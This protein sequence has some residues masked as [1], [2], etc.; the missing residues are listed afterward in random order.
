MVTSLPYGVYF[1]IIYGEESINSPFPNRDTKFWTFFIKIHTMSSVTFHSISIWLTVYLACFRYIFIK[2]S[3]S[4]QKKTTFEKNNHKSRAKLK[5]LKLLRCYNCTITTI[6]FIF[7]FCILICLPAYMYATVRENYLIDGSFNQTLK[8]YYV[9]QSDLNIRSNNLIFKLMFYSQAFLGKLIPCIF[10]VIFTTLLVFS[11]VKI[12]KNKRLLNRPSIIAFS[13]N[14][15]NSLWKRTFS[16]GRRLTLFRKSHSDINQNATIALTRYD[17]ENDEILNLDSIEPIEE[18]HNVNDE[19][20]QKRRSNSASMTAEN[21]IKNTKNG[22]FNRRFTEFRPQV[23][24]DLSPRK[25]TNNVEQIFN[26]IKIL[27]NRRSNNE[28]LRTTL[29]LVFVCALFLLAE[30][31]QCI[32]IFLS[33]IMSESFYSDVYLPLG[34]LMDIIALVNNSINFIIYCFMSKSFR[35]TFFNLFRNAFGK[36]SKEKK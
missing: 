16:F 26:P 23:K 21:F 22:M 19:E 3:T 12:N 17:K 27:N 2:T 18:V 5:F 7:I 33:I 10:L 15:S 29:M 14:R 4:Y 35:D 30:F 25:S 32:L 34:D 36:K 8:Y 1:Y 11:L 24:F 13:S 31:P 20:F 6:V 28:N 9:D